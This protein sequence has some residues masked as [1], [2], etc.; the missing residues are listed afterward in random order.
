M[1][2]QEVQNILDE[3]FFGQGLVSYNDFKNV[4][5]NKDEYIVFVLGQGNSTDFGDDESIID[6]KY[7]NIFYYASS[8]EQKDKRSLEIVQLM[9]RNNFEVIDDGTDMTA[10]PDADIFGVSMEFYKET[11]KRMDYF[12][13]KLKS[14][15]EIKTKTYRKWRE[16]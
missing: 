15:R 6:G 10:M 7:V 14:Y 12:E 2:R 11:I 9:K 5:N 16:R 8:R 1:T 13:M 4:D 3:E